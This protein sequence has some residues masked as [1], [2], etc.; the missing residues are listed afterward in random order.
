MNT[1]NNKF[2]SFDNEAKKVT[3]ALTFDVVESDVKFKRKELKTSIARSMCITALKARMCHCQN[4]LTNEILPN[5]DKVFTSSMIF[6]NTVQKHFSIVAF[7]TMEE[8]EKKFC[9]SINILETLMGLNDTELC[10]LLKAM[11]DVKPANTDEEET[12]EYLVG[13]LVEMTI[14]KGR[15]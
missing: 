8:M 1:Q 15:N 7:E 2:I 9:T 6:S 5:S 3:L 4:V 12:K 11:V 14:M 13:L 10:Q